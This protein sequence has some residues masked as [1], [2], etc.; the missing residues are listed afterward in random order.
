MPLIVTPKQLQ[1]VF[2]QMGDP[3][4]KTYS[5]I[6][7][8]VGPASATRRQGQ[9]VLRQWKKV[10]ALGWSMGPESYAILLVFDTGDI[11]LGVEAEESLGL[12]G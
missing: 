6:K 1:K 2:A 11:C 8:W 4:G 7:E 10:R 9:Y 12:E 5:G 3:T